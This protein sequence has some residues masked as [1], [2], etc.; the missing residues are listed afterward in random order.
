MAPFP[1]VLLGCCFALVLLIPVGLFVLTSVF[2]Q[3][4]VLCGLPRPSV[5]T[6]TGVMLLIWVSKT[7]SQAVMDVI[8]LEACRAAGVP[9]WEAG[10]IIVFLFLPID[11]LISAALHAG[12]MNIKFGKGVEVWFV[13]MFIYLSVFAAAGIVAAIVYFV[14]N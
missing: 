11:L 3:A 12:L 10:I 7:A 5:G 2:R 9:Q 6:A 1:L 14:M 4:C 13:Q 8:V